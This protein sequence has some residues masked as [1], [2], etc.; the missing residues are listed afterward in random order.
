MKIQAFDFSVNLLRA[1]LWQHN[2]A[3]RLETL[4]RGKQEWYDQNQTAFWTD[5][6]TDVFNL[7]TANDFGLNVWAI[8]LGLPFVSNAGEGPQDKPTWGFGSAHV[9]FGN[10]NFQPWINFP[11]TTEARRLILRL[12]YFQLT[13]RGTVPEINQFMAYLFQDMG[14]VYV[15]DGLD[16]TARYVFGFPLSQDLQIVFDTFDVLPRPAG[17]RVDYV[18]LPD[19]DGWGFGRFHYNF[20]NGNFSHG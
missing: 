20:D 9:N 17:V 3:A 5:W 12:R 18:V 16:M 11:L 14:Y 7:T 8:I 2:E 6:V 19:A 4:L 1:L 10:G 13:T 15:M